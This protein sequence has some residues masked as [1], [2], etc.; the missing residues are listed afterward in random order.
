MT[1][2]V[3]GQRV[4]GRSEK[5]IHHG[6]AETRRK[7]GRNAL[8]VVELRVKWDSN[9]HQAYGKETYKQGNS[10]KARYPIRSDHN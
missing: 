6:G 10:E 5:P 4:I 2:L 3:S 8:G 9:F 7:A 1:G